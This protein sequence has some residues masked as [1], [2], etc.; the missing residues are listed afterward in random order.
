MDP[1]EAIRRAQA[2]RL[3]D[4]DGGEVE[5]ELAPALPPADIERLADDIGVPLSRELRA[6]L[7]RTA[8][9]DGG[10]LELIDFT[11]RSLSFGAPETFPSGLPIAGDGFGNFWVLDLTPADVETAPVFFACHDPPVILYQSPDIGDFLHEAFRMLVPPHASAV[12]DVHEDRLFN[13]W[14]DNPETLEH[15][16][17]LASDEN[18]SAFAAELDDR[19]TFV[20]L[21]SSPVGMGFS[22]GR[23]GPRTNVRRHGY[24]RLF[25]YA[26]PEKTPGFLRRLFG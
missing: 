9:I 19:F 18:L 12:D 8:G 22:W 6:L 24:E 13:V 11:G 21:R 14:R 7:E 15:S 23:Y 4:E 26:R 3:L 25:A 10:P 17:A 5:F 20:D 1:L 2:T 16:A